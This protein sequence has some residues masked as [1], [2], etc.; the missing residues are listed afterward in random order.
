[1][2]FYIQIP[3]KDAIASLALTPG[4]PSVHETVNNSFRFSLR[5]DGLHHDIHF[6]PYKM[7]IKNA[8]PIDKVPGDDIQDTSFKFNGTIPLTKFQ[9]SNVKPSSFQLGQ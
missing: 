8:L 6:T 9:L 5:Y 1:M 2:Y 4:K 7:L 3:T